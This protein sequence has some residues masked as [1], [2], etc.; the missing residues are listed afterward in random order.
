MLFL[1]PA[2]R[3][4]RAS[5]I[6]AIRRTTLIIGA[7]AAGTVLSLAAVTSGLPVRFAASISASSADAPHASTR[8][9]DFGQASPSPDARHVADW[10]ADSRDNANADF[11]I[12]D[13]RDAKAYVFDAEARLRGASPVLLGA[14]LGDDSVPGIGLR[15]IAEVRPEE[16]TTP[17]GRFVA[18]RGRNLKGDDVVWVDYDA[19]VSMHRVRATKPSE[20]RLERLATPT[21]DD[22]R[23]SYGCINVP[24]AFY[25]AYVRPTVATR[26]AIVYVLPDIKPVQQVFN[27]YDVTAVRRQASNRAT[28]DMLSTR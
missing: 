26:R 1:Q 10:V 18:E 11:I 6:A 24:V 13:K 22:N 3:D 15:P 2:L 27:S 12:V 19:A 9:A 14:A 8:S 5:R 20:R 28:G 7:V 4:A 17:A 25:E 23:I 21:V 16:R